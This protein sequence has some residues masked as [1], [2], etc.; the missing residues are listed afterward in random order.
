[1]AF[2][3]WRQAHVLMT[4]RGRQPDDSPV[5]INV[6]FNGGADSTYTTGGGVPGVNHNEDVPV[7]EWGAVAFDARAVVAAAYPSGNVQ[8]ASLD[9]VAIWGWGETRLAEFALL[10]ASHAAYSAWGESLA[11][12]RTGDVLSPLS[13][14]AAWERPGAGSLLGWQSKLL[15]PQLGLDFNQARWYAPALGRFTQES[16]LGRAY[17]QPYGYAGNSP[18]EFYDGDGLSMS[19]MYWDAGGGSGRGGVTY[20]LVGGT[21]RP[22]LWGILWS[23]EWRVHKTANSAL[24]QLRRRFPDDYI[25]YRPWATDDDFLSAMASGC[26]RGIYYVGEG[27]EGYVATYPEGVFADEVPRRLSPLEFLF[28][29]SCYSDEPS[30]GGQT[31]GY[32]RSFHDFADVF[33][34]WSEPADAGKVWRKVFIYG[35]PFPWRNDEPWQQ[36]DADGAAE[37]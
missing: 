27:A 32:S 5:E 2:A 8:L 37:P 19:P 29:D 33:S 14:A 18:H 11:S 28:L 25:A 6:R 13:Q 23:K 9:G 35:L 10:G 34:G 31:A 12:P 30:V 3:L 7:G 36:G 22:T 4:L 26:T 20:V 16:P 1:V 24:R 17:E 21:A 15:D